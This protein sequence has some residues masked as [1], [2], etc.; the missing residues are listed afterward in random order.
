MI[1]SVAHEI[2]KSFSKK[3]F[4]DDDFNDE[5][6]SDEEEEGD[7]STDKARIIIVRLLVKQGQKLSLTTYKIIFEWADIICDMSKARRLEW[8]VSLLPFYLIRQP[9]LLIIPPL[10]GGP[11]YKVCAAKA[12]FLLKLNMT[13]TD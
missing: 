10:S 11:L 13:S 8:S 12:F 3:N 1:K 5:I 2:Q 6:E 4:D 9:A 7:G